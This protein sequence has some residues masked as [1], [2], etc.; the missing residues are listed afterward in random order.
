MA[1]PNQAHTEIAKQLL[2]QKSAGSGTAEERAAAAAG[3][4]Q[5]LFRSV[6]P[7]LGGAG[8]LALFVQSVKLTEVEFSC[9]G[10]IRMTAEPQ[11][12]NVEAVQHGLVS[13]L[14]KL[15]PDAASQVAT[16]LFATFFGL[17]ITF[18]GER[19]VWQIVKSAFP[20][21]IKMRPKETS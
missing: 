11:E 20:A 10:E 12:S 3:V 7:I 14:R 18:I 6:S 17:M 19:L 21:I 5:A 8:F 13:C 1:S 4:Y 16:A 9:L 15:D 2:A